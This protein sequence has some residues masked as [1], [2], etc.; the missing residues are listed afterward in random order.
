M[1]IEVRH[2]SY[3]YPSATTPALVDLN[4][5][6]PKGQF[7][8]VVGP[9][10]AGKSTLCY[11]LTG[12]AQHFFRGKLQGDVRVGGKDVASTPLEELVTFSGLVLDNP[13]SQITGARFTVREEVAFGLENLGISRVEMDERIDQA[14]HQV[15]ISNLG[16]RS[17]M[18]LSGGEQQRLAIASILAMQPKLIV[19]DEPTAQLDPAGTRQVLDVLASLTADRG[20]TIL[21]VE[22]KL[23]WLAS[24]ADR[25][26]LLN[27][28]SIVADGPPHQILGS[29][30]MADL[31]ARQTRYSMVSHLAVERDLK[32]EDETIPVTLEQAIN[33]FE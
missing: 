12:F 15:G 31:G 7:C 28:G 3:S 5:E 20:T 16:E 9:N 2:L 4:L 23:E 14:L 29:Q 10:R 8:G 13:F 32:P 11:V 33:F 24:H 25:V 19:L 30:Q 17:P 18:T 6:I 27:Q 21:L 26:I 22:H 1:M